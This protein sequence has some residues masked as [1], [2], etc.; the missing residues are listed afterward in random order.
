MEILHSCIRRMSLYNN[1]KQKKKKKPP[2]KWLTL[3]LT[4]Q[5][6]HQQMG[7]LCHAPGLIAK[8]KLYSFFPNLKDTLHA[9]PVGPAHIHKSISGP[10]YFNYWTAVIIESGGNYGNIIPRINTTI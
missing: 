10:C 1:V 6:L 5:H 8:A 3:D 9:Q 4:K 2:Q 7:P